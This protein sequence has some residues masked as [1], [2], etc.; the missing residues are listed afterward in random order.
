MKA[1]LSAQPVSVAV[2]ADD[3]QHYK[4]GVFTNNCATGLNHAILAVGYGVDKETG[5]PFYKIKNSWGP[6]WGESGFIRLERT[7]KEN[8]IGKCGVL[9]NSVYPTV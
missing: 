7:E 5:K 4:G 8:D 6:T 3:M 9:M 1:A 2:D